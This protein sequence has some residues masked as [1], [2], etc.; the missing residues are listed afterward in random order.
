MD[1]KQI[2]L[3]SPASDREDLEAEVQ[4][5]RREIEKHNQAYY[6]LDNPLISDSEYDALMRKLKDLET[7]IASGGGSIPNNS[8]SRKV[9]GRAAKKFAQIAHNP[10]MLSLDNV[11]SEEEFRDFYQKLLVRLG[12]PANTELTLSAEPKFDGLAVNLRYEYGK[13][14]AAA[15]RGDGQNGEDVTANVRE[16]SDIPKQLTGNLPDLIDIRGEIFMTKKAFA[17]LNAKSQEKSGGKLFANPRNAAAGSLRQLNPEITRERNLSFFAYGIGSYQNFTL[18]QNYSELLRTYRSF[19]IPSCDLQQQ[20]NGL[21]AAIE[22][23]TNLGKIRNELPFDIDGVVFKVD[24]FA[25]QKQ[26]GFISRAPRWAI[27]WKFPAIEV[28]TQILDIDIQVGRTGALTPVARLEPVEIA[29]VTVSNATLHNALEIA[30]KDIYI[31]DFVFLRRAGDVIPEIVKAIP[32]KRPADAR[33]FQMPAHCPVCNSAVIQDESAVIRCSGGLHCPAQKTAALI[34][35]ASRAA[36]DIQG[37][38]EKIIDDAVELGKL[39][40]PADIFRLTLED[41]KNLPRLGQKSAE[42]LV[43]AIKKARFCTLPR[44]IYALGIRE[45]GAVNARAIAEKFSS[46]EKILSATEEEFL[47]IDGIGEESAKYLKSFLSDQENLAVIQDLLQ[48]GIVLEEMPAKKT[49]NSIF[50]DKKV[51]ITGS[52]A[53]FSR[54]ELGEILRTLGA[55]VSA[56]VSKNTDFLVAGEKAGSKLDK[57]RGLG[58]QIIDAEKL[59]SELAKTRQE[60]ENA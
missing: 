12:L 8:P 32:E 23:M 31:G 34:H 5:L 14:T 4:S 46:I 47:A 36:L 37:L 15:T 50:S 22:F 35:F 59:Q 60:E 56:S 29:G 18:P 9:G 45:I 16:I 49:V 44:F 43:A 21:D 53:E 25:L 17:E 38:G 42:N 57:A 26:A 10:P 41:W 6:E 19:N 54:E 13:L 7:E 40:N 51:V 3:F 11:F 33:K 20:I 58:V 27:A 39:R 52:F 1:T 30:R 48:L 55:K 2:S 28:S 24:E